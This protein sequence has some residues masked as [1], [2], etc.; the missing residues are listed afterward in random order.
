MAN[1]LGC[2]RLNNA[3]LR[4]IRT[5]LHLERHVIATIAGVSKSL[6]DSWLVSE[7]SN[8]FR[9]MPTKSLR[10]LK[11]ELGLAQPAYLEVCAAAEKRAAQIKGA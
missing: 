3:E 11:L 8:G 2:N 7:R 6:V 5:T 4:E 10:L 9:P 1:V